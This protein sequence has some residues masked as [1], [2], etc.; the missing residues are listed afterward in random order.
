MKI[1]ILQVSPYINSMQMNNMSYAG[2]QT[3]NKVTRFQR[4]FV[5]LYLYDNND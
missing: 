5:K 4:Q 2:G 1:V 3:F